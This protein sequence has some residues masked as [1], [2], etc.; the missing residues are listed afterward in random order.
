MSAREDQ[1]IDER[2]KQL[3]EGIQGVH[4]RLDTLNGRT[5][6]LEITVAVLQWAYGLTGIVGLALFTYFFQLLA[7]G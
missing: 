1:L 2:H 3:M 6:R 5:R 4:E 7:K